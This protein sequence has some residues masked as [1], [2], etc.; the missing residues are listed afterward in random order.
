[1]SEDFRS[2]VV[3]GIIILVLALVLL[4]LPFIPKPLPPLPPGNQP[5]S[6]SQQAGASTH[7]SLAINERTLPLYPTLLQC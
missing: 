3:M 6:F 4:I 1:M 5:I 7:L 2:Q